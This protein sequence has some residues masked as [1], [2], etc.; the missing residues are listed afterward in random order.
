NTLA[1]LSNF[2]TIIGSSTGTNNFVFA[3]DAS[4]V[5]TVDGNGTTS[6]I[7]LKGNIADFTVTESSD[8]TLLIVNATT[9]LYIIAIGMDSITY[10]E[11][12]AQAATAAVTQASNKW[13]ADGHISNSNS[14][15][16]ALLKLDFESKMTVDV[17]S[18][19]QEAVVQVLEQFALTLYENYKLP[20]NNITFNDLFDSDG[21]GTEDLFSAI[22]T[23]ITNLKA[24]TYADLDTLIAAI[25][26]ELPNFGGSDW[27]TVSYEGGRADFTFAFE[28]LFTTTQEFAL[29]LTNTT[30]AGVPMSAADGGGTSKLQFEEVGTS[31]NCLATYD[32]ADLTVN[33][34]ASFNVA[35]DLNV[36]DADP[37]FIFDEGSSADVDI[38]I[39]ESGLEFHAKLKGDWTSAMAVKVKQGQLLLDTQLS[40]KLFASTDTKFEFLISDF[41]NGNAAFNL[42]PNSLEATG[43]LVMNLP[44]LYGGNEAS[45]R[46]GT[47]SGLIVTATIDNTGVQYAHQINPDFGVAGALVDF[48]RAYGADAVGGIFQDLGGSIG[49]S[50]NIDIPLIGNLGS[51]VASGLAAGFTAVGNEL[52]GKWTDEVNKSTADQIQQYEISKA[53]GGTAWSETGSTFGI[54]RTVLNIGIDKLAA[55]VPFFVGAADVEGL[56]ANDPTY[57]PNEYSR[58]G[59]GISANGIELELKLVGNLQ[60]EVPID[61]SATLPGFDLDIADDSK[62]LLDVSFNTD[63]KLGYYNQL[64]TSY[65]FLDV[66]NDDEIELNVSATLTDGTSLNAVLGGLLDVTLTEQAASVDGRN[67]GFFGH[68]GLDLTG[69]DGNTV[70]LKRESSS[71]DWTASLS[72]FADIDLEG[73]IGAGSAAAPE[74]STVIHYEQNFVNLTYSKGS[75]FDFTL[76]SSPVLEFENVELDLGAFLTKTLKPFVDTFNDIMAPIKPFITGDA[77]KSDDGFLEQEV[78]FLNGLGIIDDSVNPD[79]KVQ[80]VEVLYTLAALYDTA[81]GT[82]YANAIKGIYTFFQAMDTLTVAMDGGGNGKINFGNFRIGGKNDT[83]NLTSA[84]AAK[85]AAE[86]PDKKA[87]LAKN[88][89]ADSSGTTGTA[90]NDSKSAFDNQSRGLE[91]T[92]TFNAGFELPILED[93]VTMF[94]LL[95]G[96]PADLIILNFDA[97]FAIEQY[98]GAT[99]FGVLNAGITFRAEMGLNL[100]IGVDSTGEV[101]VRDFEDGTNPPVYLELSTLLTV[102]VGIKGIVEAGIEGGLTGR[103]NFDFD[104]QLRENSLG[105]VDPTVDRIYLSDVHDPACLFNINGKITAGLDLFVKVNLPTP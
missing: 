17:I 50:V 100:D 69:G 46:Y 16:L 10:Q 7:E 44:I 11:T 56:I 67:S 61:V 38:S 26:S 13:N 81:N 101:F 66:S 92:A 59:F 43:E 53:S 65:F 52:M 35:F 105:E 32:L 103:I 58:F 39:S 3:T 86:D 89:S 55:E 29:D 51:L 71:L 83:T 49:G 18:G 15:T 8:G 95:T 97:L 20:L 94:K 21:D 77:D 87:E 34:L 60:K 63:L 22:D 99:F 73:V 30:G 24:G 84:N 102:S 9:G 1:G 62:I 91:K 74:V 19:V 47:D 64:N 54:I 37:V 25:N 75:G 6:S 90:A 33:A 78:G 12:D 36:M 31:T 4:G 70:N 96:Q 57:D 85:A 23:A 93:P 98:I 28:K 72:I 79:G 14:T 48:L 80:M 42:T 41:N 27:L 45:F 5:F 104:D 76:G 2:E 40:Q 82:K 68:I 88:N